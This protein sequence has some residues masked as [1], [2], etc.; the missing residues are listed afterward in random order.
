M[1]DNTARAFIGEPLLVDTDAEDLESEFQD[2]SRVVARRVAWLALSHDVDALLQFGR[3]TDLA[4][5][6]DAV[7]DMAARLRQ[8]SRLMDL[9]A[10][11]MAAAAAVIRGT[12][13]L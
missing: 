1:D 4:A 3:A 7:S 2:R 5:A 13:V 8:V 10:G 9:A 12:E 6:S 11:R